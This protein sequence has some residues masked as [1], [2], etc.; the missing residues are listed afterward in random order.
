MLCD[1][2]KENP[3]VVHLT[4]IVSGEIRTSHLCERCAAEQG[5]ETQASTS[6]NPLG[7]FLQEVQQ[8]AG[9]QGDAVRCSFCSMTLRDFRTS[10]RLGCALCYGSFERNLR[11]LLRRVHG[12]SRHVGRQYEVPESL[13]NEQTGTLL[14]LRDRLQRAIDSEQF[15]VAATLRDQ[16]RGME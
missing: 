14:E 7:V 5:V 13:D 12:S 16:I 15:E 3:A 11:E 2:C 8:Q 4:K 9:Q 1:N 10:G 6:K